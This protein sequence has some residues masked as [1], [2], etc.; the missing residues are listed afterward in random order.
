MRTQIVEQLK[1]LKHER[2]GGSP[3]AQ[4]LVSTKETLMMQIGNTVGAE[5]R[6][7]LRAFAES[8]RVFFPENLAKA[9][10]IP[11][12]VL[13]LVV[14]TG[15]GSTAVV[16]AAHDTLPGHPLYNVKLAAESLNLK[17]SRKSDRTERRVEI[18]GR[19]LNEMARL[20]SS[21]DLGREG[22]IEMVAALF[23]DEM[24]AVRKDLSDLQDE[25]DADEAVRIASRVESKADEYQAIFKHGL[26]VGR[27]SF[28]MALLNL[29]QVSVKALEIL[30]EKQSF[31]SNVL[32]EAQLSSAVGRKIDAFA[33]H[34][35][36]TQDGLTSGAASPSQL[37]TVKA[38]AAVDEAKELLSQGDFRAAVK[39]VSEGADLVTEAESADKNPP[40]EEPAEAETEAA[41]STEEVS[42]TPAPEIEPASSQP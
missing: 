24:N 28:R 18:A 41:T 23:S 32:P 42:E 1:A 25:K 9:M 36:T 6:T 39:K 40:V 7:G 3:D 27:P 31:A 26:F 16:A 13:L 12:M 38:Q 5:R 14:G 15:V 29:D 35:A 10:A 11:A 4:W 30:V 21:P 34:V 37:L 22:K 33:A 20:A 17:L 8:L 19:R 2:A